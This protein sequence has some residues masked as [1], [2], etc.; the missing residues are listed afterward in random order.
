MANDVAVTRDSKSAR[1]SSSGSGSVAPVGNTAEHEFLIELFRRNL[2][3]AAILLRR[4]LNVHIPDYVTAVLAS[5]DA[6]DI[7]GIPKVKKA[8]AV[9]IY[10]HA[11]PA[12]PPVWAVIVEVQRA[13][14]KDKRF[15]WPVYHALVRARHRCPTTLLVLCP[16][17]K[18]ARWAR[19]PI[20]TGQPGYPW[21]PLATT[22]RELLIEVVDT[23]NETELIMLAVLGHPERLDDP[24]LV[25]AVTRAFE[26]LE[27]NL[28]LTYADGILQCLPEHAKQAWRKLMTTAHYR[29]Q[30][31]F[32]TGYFN[33]GKAEVVSRCRG[34][35]RGESRGGKP[36]KAARMV[37]LILEQRRVSL[38]AAVRER[39]T[40]CTDPG[41]LEDWG[42]RALTVT[43]ADHLFD[44]NE[45]DASSANSAPST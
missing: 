36:A 17:D 8:D 45:K 21:A 9:V 38:S 1:R 5:E 27:E 43:D 18:T 42:R 14:D 30:S 41:Q 34:E 26:P 32:A 24:Q 40:A 19:Q 33:E 15:S 2:H 7:T 37:L 31:D 44:W 39:I 22:P 6:T 13:E 28:A 20:D 35:S 29:Y 10:L 16:D 3:L 4:Y 25:E 11:N 23:S 12:A